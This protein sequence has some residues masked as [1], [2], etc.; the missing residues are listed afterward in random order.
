MRMCDWSSDVCSSDLQ[1]GDLDQH[2]LE[3]PADLL[4]TGIGH[5]AERAVLAAAL[6]DR[7]ER[8]RPLGARLGQAVELLDLREADV[9]LRPAGQIGRASLGK[10]GVSTGRSRWAPYI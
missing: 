10:G 8:A 2:V 7:Y 4:A 9:D 3:R 5:H 1:L 6:H